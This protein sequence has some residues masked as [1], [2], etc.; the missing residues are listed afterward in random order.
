MANKKK[1]IIDENPMAVLS[2]MDI[3][4]RV[5]KGI[6]EEYC[7]Y[8]SFSS[9]KK[10]LIYAMQETAKQY[11]DEEE[12]KQELLD[13]IEKLKNMDETQYRQEYPDNF[14]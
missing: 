9:A 10:N 12:I 6:E 1:Y 13:G 5:P 2:E 14:N 8:N 11:E 3:L 7:I 4:F